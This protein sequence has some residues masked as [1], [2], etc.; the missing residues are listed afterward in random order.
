[1]EILKGYIGRFI[2]QNEDNG[3]TVAEVIVEGES[4]VCVGLMRGFSEGEIVEME[5]EYTVHPRYLEQFKISRIKAVPPEDKVS[6]MRYLGSGAIKGIG[7]TLAQR[8]VDYFGEDTFRVIEEEPERLAEIK[9]ISQKKAREIA[10]QLVEKREMRN[11]ALYLQQYGISQNLADKIYRQYGNEVY[12]IIREN[13]YRMVEDIQGVG[14]KIA[15]AIAS[16]AGIRVDSDYRIRCGI[17]YELYQQTMEGNCYYPRELLLDKTAQLL[18]LEPE[19]IAGQLMSLAMDQQVL[20]KKMQDEER[21]YPASYYKEE[22]ACARK[23]LELRDSYEYPVS[24]IS[25]QKI[26]ERIITIEASMEMNL[27]GLQREAVAACIKNGVFILSGGPGTGKT[28]TINAIL[29]YLEAEQMDFAL[30]APTGRAAKRMTETTGYE[31]KTIHRL[32]EINGELAE[33]GHRIKFERNEDNPLEVDAVVIDEV[34]MVDIHL[35][36]ALLAAL[37]P[38]TKLILIGDVSQLPS[39]GPGQILKDIIDSGRFACVILEKIFRQAAESHIVSYAHKINK[40]EIIDFSQKYRDFFLLA[41]D[42]PEVIYQYIEALVK[43]KVP[44]EF[45]IDP[46]ESQILTPMRKGPLGSEALNRV[47]QERLNP[48]APE[49]KEV[50]YGDTLFRVGDKIMQIKN[51]YDLKWEIVGN[52]NITIAEG[53][54][55][56]NGDIGTI[57]DINDFS[58]ILKVHFDDGK[59][60]EYSFQELDELEHAFA[61][62]IHKSQGSEYPVVILPILNGPKMLLNRN[63]LYTGVTRARDCVIILGNPDTVL[64]MIE[65]DQVQ[66]RYTSL[67][68]RLMEMD[69]GMS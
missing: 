44:K 50:Q 45:Q 35:L 17:I 18:G 28:T 30:A 65:A 19:L 54:G 39:V 43:D 25:D 1:M 62:T 23:L 6:L 51:D 7:N 4:H 26:M 3:Y 60:V 49:K 48:P 41:K 52:Y 29:K 14:F 21:V 11:A 38:G 8:I 2:F 69:L 40:G 37:I 31:A 46:L 15:D 61:I 55:V 32:L 5:G 58:K 24:Q 64:E 9:G 53:T 13:P 42:R 63:L 66:K 34:S 22:M 68:E 56:F 57:L 27:D 16:H 59:L 20:L 36:R 12:Q 47:F 33:E 67:G 10:E